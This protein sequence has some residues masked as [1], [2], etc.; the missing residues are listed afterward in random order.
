MQIL[1]CDVVVA[2]GGPA[3][4][5][6]AVKAAEAGAHVILVDK[7]YVGKSGCGTF[8]AGSFKAYIKEE[9]S[10]DLWYGK[11]VEEG[12]FINDQDWLKQHFETIGDRVHDL[13]HYGVVFEKNPDGTY[14]RIEGQG[15]S[16]ER[17]IKTLMFHG[18]QF[19]EVMRKACEK[20]GVKIVDR[21]MC[22]SLVHDKKKPN[23]IRGV[24]GFHGVTGE[25]YLFRAKA[26]VLTTGAQAYKSHYADLHMVTG[27]SHI[28]GLNAGAALC[29]YE[30]NC[31]QLTHA[32]FATHGMNIS[33][34]L[35]AKF[36][37]A[38]GE[39]FTAKYD[40]EY[41]SHG[42][43][44]RISASM[45]M[46][47][48]FGRG[49]LYFDYSSYTPKDWE[50]FARTLPLMHRSY[51]QAG[52]VTNEGVCRKG[53]LEWVSALIGN[54][55]FG[56]GLWIDINGR[57]T[58]EGLYAA[59]DASYGPTSGVEGFCAYA[60]PAASTT[61]TIAGQ[62]AAAYAA[63]VDAVEL[64]QQEIDAAAWAM[65]E[66]MRHATGCDPAH[67]VIAVQE[68]L[69]PYDVY[70]LR[71]EEKMQR[72][73][74]RIQEIKEDDVPRLK[75]ADPHGLRF[76]LEAR[77]MVL[78][79]EAML[80]AALLRKESRGSHLRLDYP[81]IDNENWLKWIMIEKG[82]DNGLAL[83]TKDIP[84][85][86]YPLRPERKRELHASIAAARKLG[87]NI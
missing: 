3:G 74:C 70:I 60:M 79:A 59:G 77:N 54:V 55:G 27:D 56:G 10:Y 87:E 76:A 69:F 24:M 19:M 2:G 83:S 23:A 82:S 28:M 39:D 13:E 29:N 1:D 62:S 9:D 20:T 50:L 57:T 53:K 15:S 84:I 14:N 68:A 44:W 43:L 61:G 85:D 73:L 12:F 21:V 58:L 6:A 31:H 75:A 80:T 63:S 25:L 51:V 86:R 4:T 34:G 36:V 5:F 11:A 47:V 48:H 52:Y 81:E 67:V 26:V 17:P 40:P 7:A 37:N 16:D 64:D 49:P 35:G 66:P 33:Q 8:G 22:V 65:T 42:N 45:A 38:F 46:E 30:F 78:C 71:T 72:A 32:G 18:P 41:A